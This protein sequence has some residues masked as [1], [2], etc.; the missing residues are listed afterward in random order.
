[1]T[2]AVPRKLPVG[3]E[4]ARAG[5]AGTDRAGVAGVDRVGVADRAADMEMDKEVA[6]EVGMGAD[7][8]KARVMEMDREMGPH[9]ELRVRP[10]WLGCRI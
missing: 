10:V 8:D 3:A 9:R 7:K 5:E 2:L 4:T 6:R 1:M